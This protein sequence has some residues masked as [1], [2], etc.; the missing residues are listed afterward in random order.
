MALFPNDMSSNDK[1]HWSRYQPITFCECTSFEIHHLVYII[2]NFC[3]KFANE[4]DVIF[5]IKFLKNPY[6]DFKPEGIRINIMKQW[7]K[8]L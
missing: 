7:E 2:N 4:K 3:N 8:F 1:F 5:C 6:E